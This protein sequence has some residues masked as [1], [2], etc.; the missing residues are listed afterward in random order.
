MTVSSTE[1]NRINGEGFHTGRSLVLQLTEY[2]V[3]A[4]SWMLLNPVCQ[5]NVCQHDV[6]TQFVSTT[7]VPCTQCY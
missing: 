5:H 2:T 3:E 6:S 1:V 7:F 4:F